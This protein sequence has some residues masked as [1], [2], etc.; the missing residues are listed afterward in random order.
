[1]WKTKNSNLCLYFLNYYMKKI[2]SRKLRILIKS[3]FNQ[4]K[5]Y[6]CIYKFSYKSQEEMWKTKNS[7]LCLYFLNYYMKK[8]LSRKLRIFI[9]NIV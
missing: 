8:I 3:N 9:K 1:M 5:W 6:L 2:L 7:N 4:L